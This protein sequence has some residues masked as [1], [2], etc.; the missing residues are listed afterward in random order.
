M[1]PGYRGGDVISKDSNPVGVLRATVEK[2]GLQDIGAGAVIVLSFLIVMLNIYQDNSHNQNFIETSLEDT[3]SMVATIAPFTPG[4]DEDINQLELAINGSDE[5]YI[6]RPSLADSLKSPIH[7]TVQNGDTISNI[8]RR[9]STTV[10]TILEENKIKASE[11]DKISPGSTITIPPYTTNDSLAWLDEVNKIKEEKA[12]QEAEKKKRSL[13]LL[14]TK[15][16]LPYRDSSSARATAAAGFD[17]EKEGGF[18]LPIASKGITRGISG[19]HTG[20]DYRADVGTPVTA[21]RSGRVIEVTG[22][23]S[24]GWGISVVLDHGNGLT[25]RYAHLSRIGVSLGQSI[26]QG[27][28][29]GYSGNSGFSTGPHLH[30]ETRINGRVVSPY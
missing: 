30:F 19:G 16:S 25:S 8:A 14:A 18:T 17:G 29:V 22:G 26:T 12:R 4:V 6:E 20:I 1:L 3:K 2:F 21:G 15:R 9:Y 27:N 28:V 7:Y 23:W 13:A 10:A 5:T 11:I 24:G